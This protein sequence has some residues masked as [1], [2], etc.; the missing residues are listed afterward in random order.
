MPP[1]ADKHLEE[2]ILR[3]AQKLWRMRGTGGFTL[4][5][6]ARA[7]GTTTPTIYQRFR[8]KEAIQLALALRVRDALDA[9][10]FSSATLEDACR[11][12]LH[13]A[14]NNP[15]EY[16]LIR[17]LWPRSAADV[18][19]PIRAW[20]LSQLAARFGGQPDEYGEVYYAFVILCHGA[21]SMLTAT[22]PDSPIRVE[23]R[24]NCIG[25][26]EKLIANVGIFRARASGHEFN[27]R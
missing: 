27:G 20:L 10:V 22:E 18:P 12:Y 9:E 1:V 8:N 13:Y 17:V 21:A 3:A 16:E 6:I 19:R 7:A 26:F 24:E 15:Q 5:E 4:R 11:R 23:I 25:V 2:R 14:E